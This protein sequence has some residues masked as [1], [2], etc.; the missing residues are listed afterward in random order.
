MVRHA[1]LFQLQAL[2]LFLVQ[3]LVI[4]RLGALQI[5]FQDRR[6]DIDRIPPRLYTS[7]IR[8]LIG[9]LMISSNAGITLPDALTETSITPLIDCRNIEV[10]PF[11]AGLK[12]GDHDYDQDDK[13]ADSC[14]YPDKLFTLLLSLYFF[15]ISLSIFNI[16]L[17]LLFPAFLP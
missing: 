1:L 10:F 6:A 13:T 4:F 12:H 16:A 5:Q 17:I 3:L 7:T 11:K 9:E 14:P 15:E 2:H 8:E